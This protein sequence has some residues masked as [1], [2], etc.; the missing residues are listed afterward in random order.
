[1]YMCVCV[2]DSPT[3]MIFLLYTGINVAEIFLKKNANMV[4][5]QFMANLG[6]SRALMKA[7][8]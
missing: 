3:D 6:F 7:I 1:M 4:E 2:Y 8:N 5:Q